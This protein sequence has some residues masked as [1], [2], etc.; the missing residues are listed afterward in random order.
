MLSLFPSRLGNKLNR[1]DFAAA[2]RNAQRR[3][4]LAQHLRAGKRPT[5]EILDALEATFGPVN[6]Y[7]NTRF[8][9]GPVAVASSAGNLFNP[10]TTTGGVNC[11]S[12][13]FNNLYVVL[14]HLRVVN[15]TTTAANIS[16]FIGATGA[17][18]A[19]TSFAWATT[20]V[21]G[22]GT[23]L[24]NWLDWYGSRRLATTDFLVGLAGT[25]ASLAINGEGEIGV[26]T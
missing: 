22:Y 25:T 10:G 23:G 3:Q 15:Y 19:A 9:F 14:T 26:G 13:P 5:N 16:L 11:T 8:Q 21:P 1:L 12:A 7:S 20:P 18:V 24:V 4:K 17:S 6:F 2:L